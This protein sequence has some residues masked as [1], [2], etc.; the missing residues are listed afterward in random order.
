MTFLE[1]KQREERLANRERLAALRAKRY[2]A[3]FER[4]PHNPKALPRHRVQGSPPV[5]GNGKLIVDFPV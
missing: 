3:R 4:G 2:R 5:T 1:K